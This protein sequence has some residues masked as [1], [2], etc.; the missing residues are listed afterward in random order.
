MAATGVAD[1]PLAA[2][3]EPLDLVRISLDERIYVK[4]RND[5]ELKGR[6]HV[7][8]RDTSLWMQAGVFTRLSVCPANMLMGSE[9]VMVICT[10]CISYVAPHSASAFFSLAWPDYP[11]LKVPGICK[12]M[13]TPSLMYFYFWSLPA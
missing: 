2:I 5:R 4:L 9:K 3:E 1:Q 7:S 8:L 6:L 13:A 10:D 12:T 11:L